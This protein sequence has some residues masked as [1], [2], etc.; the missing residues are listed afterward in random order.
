VKPSWA[1][2]A[3]A[4]LGKGAQIA[5]NGAIATTYDRRA[6]NFKGA[7]YLAATVI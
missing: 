1:I 4:T 2:S 7:I 6:T 3:I 5:K